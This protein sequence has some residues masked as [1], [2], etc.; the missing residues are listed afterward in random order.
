MCR[1]EF[2]FVFVAGDD[3]TDEDTFEVAPESAWTVKVGHGPT[4]A[5]FSVRS[6]VDIRRVLTSMMEADQT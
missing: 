2:D 4:R 5:R 3:R 1:E 6:V